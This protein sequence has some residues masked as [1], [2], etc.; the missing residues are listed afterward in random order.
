[1]TLRK[2]K[3]QEK[4]EAEAAAAAA[5]AGNFNS[6]LS[7]NEGSAASPSAPRSGVQSGA[8]SRRSS[9]SNNQ[10]NSSVIDRED[11]KASTLKGQL[12]SLTSIESEGARNSNTSLP[13]GVKAKA[14][15]SD[16]VG[17]QEEEER[18]RR[19]RSSRTPDSQA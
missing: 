15:F 12:H 1:M 14:R 9:A 16:V 18:G 7:D 19:G 2:R 8:N 4:L 5:S 17:V 11:I 13:P 10:S 6:A 3:E